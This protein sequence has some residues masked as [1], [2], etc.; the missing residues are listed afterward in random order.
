MGRIEAAN[1]GFQVWDPLN[2]GFTTIAGYDTAD[3]WYEIGFTRTGSQ[4]D[5]FIYGN[6]VAS[7]TN[8]ILPGINN[9]T[10]RSIFF[11]NLS[12]TSSVP[13]PATIAVFGLMAATGLGLRFRRRKAAETA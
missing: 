4:F 10:D 9:G 5:Y 2:G 7:L 6:Q 13:E 12:S 3:Q 1:G 8:V 11:D